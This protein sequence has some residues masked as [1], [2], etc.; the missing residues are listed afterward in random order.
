MII[1]RGRQKLKSTQ[2]IFAGLSI[3]AIA[4]LA[5]INLLAIALLR[6]EPSCTFIR[7]ISQ[8]LTFCNLTALAT[9][10][11]TGVL[12]PFICIYYAPLPRHFALLDICSFSG[13][14]QTE[15]IRGQN[16]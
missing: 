16:D 3:P 13:G 9:F 15:S 6:T 10:T 14:L 12:R 4:P 5:K 11:K 1:K 2:K 8:H 7:H